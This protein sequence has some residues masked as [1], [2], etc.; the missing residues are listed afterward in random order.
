MK[1]V[2]IA[3]SAKLQEKING[4]K[5]YFEHK[6]FEV[7]DYPVV[8]DE[9]YFMEIY[10]EVHKKFFENI[11]KTDY[12]FVMNEDKN[13]I[14]GYIGAETFAE[15]G[16]AVTQKLLYDKPI[17]VVLYQKPSESVFSYDEVCLWHSLGWISFLEE[18]EHEL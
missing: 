15:M 11:M 10:S 12:L 16:F 7:L 9:Q 18:V 14:K 2:V 5:N 4:W 1:K 3:G 8:I 6:G 13:F 17:V